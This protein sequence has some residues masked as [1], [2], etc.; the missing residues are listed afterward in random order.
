MVKGQHYYTQVARLHAQ[1]IKQGFLSSL[2]ED[3][4]TL[5]YESIDEQADAVLLT[6]SVNGS[7]VGFVSGSQSLIPIYGR[8]LLKLPRLIGALAPTLLKPRKIYKILELL[9]HSLKTAAN[10]GSDKPLPEFE[11]LSI[12]VDVSQRRNGV[13]QRLYYQLKRYA[14]DNKVTAFKILV[15]E[16]LASAHKFYLAMG[17]S[18][19]AEHKVHGDK[20]SLVYVQQQ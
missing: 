10:Q 15:G 16:D 18:L 7:V 5:L 1:G 19:V 6:E 2:G 9:S 8:L 14:R 20:R 13:A 11:L 17:A 12:A 3:F 4:L